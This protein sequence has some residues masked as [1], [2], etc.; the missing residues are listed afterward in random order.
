MVIVVPSTWTSGI[1]RHAKF[2]SA[3]TRETPTTYHHLGILHIEGTQKLC[4]WFVRMVTML[5]L[6]V[7]VDST[8]RW[9]FGRANYYLMWDE[10]ILFG[11]NSSSSGGYQICSLK[12]ILASK[13][14]FGTDRFPSD[15]RHLKVDNALTLK[16]WSQFLSDLLIHLVIVKKVKLQWFSQKIRVC[17]GWF[18]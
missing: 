16:W 7:H 6:G 14:P 2:K 18:S 13:Y 10:I 5:A 15:S 8:N 1:R 11:F 17:V 12:I 3:K 9:F 4:F